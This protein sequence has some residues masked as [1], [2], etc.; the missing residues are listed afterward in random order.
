[1]K[2]GMMKAGI[3]KQREISPYDSR[4]PSDP[5]AFLEC[6]ASVFDLTGAQVGDKTLVGRTGIEIAEE[7]HA[8]KKR[9]TQKD[10]PGNKSRLVINDTVESDCFG[11]CLAFTFR[12]FLCH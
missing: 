6:P 10:K 11:E 8:D 5:Q 2:A 12:F 1:M 9:N 3:P 4:A 7:S